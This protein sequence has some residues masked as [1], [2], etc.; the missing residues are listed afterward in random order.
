MSLSRYLKPEMD[1][2]FARFGN[3]FLPS[4]HLVATNR[5]R[6]SFFFTINSSPWN[7]SGLKIFNARSS[8][9]APNGKRSA[10]VMIEQIIGFLLLEKLACF[11][12][13]IRVSTFFC[14]SFF[15]FRPLS[16]SDQSDLSF[17]FFSQHPSSS[18][19]RSHINGG[20]Q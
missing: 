12:F 6:F 2:F 19:H 4:L 7:G 9:R 5:A 8:F 10:V 16:L 11:D 17:S 15:S 20:M 14:Q 3:R 18:I 1:E 13:Q